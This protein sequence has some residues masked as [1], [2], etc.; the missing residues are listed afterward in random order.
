MDKKVLT[1]PL[2]PLFFAK[3]KINSAVNYL[4]VPLLTL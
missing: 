2:L 4:L 3:I 1:K